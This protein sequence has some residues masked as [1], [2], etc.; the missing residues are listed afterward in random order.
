M[1]IDPWRLMF[2]RID[3]HII[4]SIWT[5][6]MSVELCHISYETK[7]SQIKQNFPLKTRL[8]DLFRDDCELGCLFRAFIGFSLNFLFAL[9][10]QKTNTER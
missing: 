5:D 8:M 7:V 9:I 2:A 6:R 1:S 3:D 4:K 10:F